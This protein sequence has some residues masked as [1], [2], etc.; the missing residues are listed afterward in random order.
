MRQ[1]GP[2]EDRQLL[3]AH[4]RVHP[5]DRRD[6]GLDELGWVVPGGR[7]DRAPVD[8]QHLPGMICGPLSLGCPEPSK[9]RPRI[10]SETPSSTA[11]GTGRPGPRC[12]VRRALEDLDHGLLGRDLEHLAA[13]R[14]P[15]AV[16]I[17]TSSPNLTSATFSTRKR[18]DDVGYGLYS[19]RMG[20]L[21]SGSARVSRA[22]R[23]PRPSLQEPRLL[24]GHV[25]HPGDAFPDAEGQDVLQLG[26][27]FE[28]MSAVRWNWRMVRSIR[29]C[30]LSEV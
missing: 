18:A 29:Y 15:P 10:S 14:R 28:A 27:V 17:S 4:E 21:N 20:P 13:P 24:F 7:V 25:L 2:G 22:P 23:P 16:S 6:A 30:F 26:A 9:T 12:P 19:L 3:A 8:V 5:V 1:A 11:P